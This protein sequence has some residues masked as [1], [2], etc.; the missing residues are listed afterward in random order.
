MVWENLH[1]ECK[2]ISHYA[3]EQYGKELDHKGSSSSRSRVLPTT[4]I[5]RER[6]SRIQIES[7]ICKGSWQPIGYNMQTASEHVR[8]MYNLV[9]KYE[10]II[11]MTFIP[12]RQ[13]Q[14]LH[15]GK[16]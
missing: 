13:W 3:S 5:L 15:Q 10:P 11:N 2:T 8:T 1:P 12:W 9:M 14:P 16:N 7:M 6:N 4:N